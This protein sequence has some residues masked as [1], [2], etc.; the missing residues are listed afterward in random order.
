[1]QNSCSDA[2][3]VEVSIGAR[4]FVLSRSPIYA[5]VELFP[6]SHLISC[7]YP[8]KY[9]QVKSE[10]SRRTLNAQLLLRCIFCGKHWCY[11][12]CLIRVPYLCIEEVDPHI[13][14]DFL[15][16]PI[17]IRAS[18]TRILPQNTECTIAA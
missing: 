12:N 2:N 8:L 15:C 5:L 4:E 16:I 18:Q 11:K 14:F 13:T 7:A 17:E 3:F 9:R 1:M 10:S 6:L